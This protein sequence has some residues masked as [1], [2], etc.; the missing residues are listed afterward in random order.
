MFYRGESG[1]DRATT[2]TEAEQAFTRFVK[3]VEPRLSYAL[4]AAYGPETGCPGGGP[5]HDCGGSQELDAVKTA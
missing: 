2:S 4:A 1:M 5:D 3:E